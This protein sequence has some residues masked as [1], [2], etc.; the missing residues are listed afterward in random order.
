MKLDEIDP[1]S[2][3]Q[4]HEYFKNQP[5]ETMDLLNESLMY[6]LPIWIG[7]KV[8]ERTINALSNED[9]K[10]L[11]QVI[12]LLSY[13]TADS[14]NKSR[15][16]TDDYDLEIARIVNDIKNGN[17]DRIADLT[18]EFEIRLSHVK[19][20]LTQRIDNY[21]YS[22]LSKKKKEQIAVLRAQQGKEKIIS[23]IIED[24]LKDD[25]D[26]QQLNFAIDALEKDSVLFDLSAFNSK[27]LSRN[28]HLIPRLIRF[29]SNPSCLVM[30]DAEN[31]L[32]GV[33]VPNKLYAYRML[34][35]GEYREFCRNLSDINQWKQ[36]TVRVC[37]SIREQIEIPIPT[38]K[39][40]KQIISELLDS[41][42]DRR[43]EIAL[44]TMYA[45]IEGILWDL[46]CEANKT[47]RIFDMDRKRFVDISTSELFETTRIREVLERTA[48]KKHVDTAFLREFCD[49]IYIER[50][51]I[52]HGRQNCFQNCNNNFLCLMQKLMA[53]EY[54]LSLEVEEYRSALFQMWDAMPEDTIE[55]ILNTYIENVENISA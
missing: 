42:L 2:S 18:R 50:N 26:V 51:P 40:R 14:D 7:E 46:V 21:K 34:T 48:L 43:Y 17:E 39:A 15:D 53:L 8:K 55:R 6:F 4:I 44:I 27:A 37:K 23:K 38:I 36:M 3:E 49:E 31:I 22:R 1:N 35:I 33:D 12:L 41:L 20:D 10:F 45:E 29:V 32:Q 13:D 11:F 25:G 24:A 9:M 52:L 30:Q 28:E 5:K 47:D 19:N 54:V 16:N